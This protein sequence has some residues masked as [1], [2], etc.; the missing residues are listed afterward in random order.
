[1]KGYIVKASTAINEF[2]FA[3]NRFTKVTYDPSDKIQL[4]DVANDGVYTDIKRVASRNVC[5]GFFNGRSFKV[6]E[7]AFFKPVQGRKENPAFIG[8]YLS[9]TNDLHFEGRIILIK[10][11]ENDTDLPD[12]LDDLKQL[13]NDDKFFIYGPDEK[14]IK[15]LD[16]KFDIFKGVFK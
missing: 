12:A 4:E 5:E 2:T 3:D 7:T 11:G 14:A 16:K 10:K 9:L 1:M 15:E 6:C 13:E 8:K